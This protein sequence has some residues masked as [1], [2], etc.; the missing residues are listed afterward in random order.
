ML[1]RAVEL[2]RAGRHRD[3]ENLLCDVPPTAVTPAMLDLRARIHAQQGHLAEAKALWTRLLG[4]D[5]TNES[6]KAALDCISKIEAQDAPR[7]DDSLKTTSRAT[8]P[9]STVAALMALWRIRRRLTRKLKEIS[10][11]AAEQSATATRLGELERAQKAWIHGLPI[12]ERPNVNLNVPGV[13]LRGEGSEVVVTFDPGLFS[14]AS[15]TLT[16]EAKPTLSVLGWQLEPYVGSISIEVVGQT[17]KLPEPC[18]HASRDITTLGMLRAM[19]VFEHLTQTSKLQGRMFSLRTSTE[20]LLPS[21]IQEPDNHT[22]DHAVVL[23]IGWG[24][25]PVKGS[26][27]TSGPS[28]ED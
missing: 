8:R 26:A 5:P 1:A 13:F 22:G 12:E 16:K 17:D 27:S 24:T 4:L 19:A 2:A 18:D 3:A 28:I 9:R 20:F 23:R 21:A 14:A 11:I 7:N 6:A 15:A 10:K 25:L